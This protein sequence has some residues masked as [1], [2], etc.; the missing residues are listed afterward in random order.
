M[1]LFQNL[2]LYPSYRTRLDRLVTT[3][4]ARS[5]G[6]RRRVFLADRYGAS[7]LLLPVLENDS[8]AFFTTGDDEATQR[9]WAQENGLKATVGQ[10]Q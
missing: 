5:F 2:G 3:A 8:A 6:E 7:H 4:C 10:R 9:Q 1:R